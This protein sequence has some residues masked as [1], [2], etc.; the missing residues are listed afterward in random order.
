MW[1]EQVRGVWRSRGVEEE[2]GPGG[3]EGEPVESEGILMELR[4]RRW[5]ENHRKG[6]LVVKIRRRPVFWGVRG[7]GSSQV[8]LMELLDDEAKTDG[9]VR[10]A[11][12]RE[13]ED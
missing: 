10:F 4:L 13:S 5:L 9:T 11:T 6:S 7:S 3:G 1:P 2:V 12:T 8:E